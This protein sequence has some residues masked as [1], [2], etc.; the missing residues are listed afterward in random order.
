MLF[1]VT[2]RGKL[3]FAYF[4]ILSITVWCS[5]IFS[6]RFFRFIGWAQY[7]V[8][9]GNRDLQCGMQ[10]PCY[11]SRG[12]CY[13]WKGARELQGNAEQAMKLT[14]LTKLSERT[15]TKLWHTNPGS[16]WI[17]KNCVVFICVQ[18]NPYQKSGLRIVT[19]SCLH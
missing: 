10:F 17:E 4:N 12:A 13:Y 18:H 16:L 1:I 9:F 7:L 15:F 2:S 6:A 19:L 8:L 14:K 5:W 3:S 11:F